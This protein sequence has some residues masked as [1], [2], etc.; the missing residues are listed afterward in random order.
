MNKIEKISVGIPVLNGEKK[1]SNAIES[2]I[3]QDYPNIEIIISN[4][5]S[6]DNTAS[7]CEKYASKDNRIKIFHQRER[8]SAFNNFIFVL[9]ESKGKF[10]KWLAHDDIIQS[11][12]SF[13]IAV[14]KLNEHYD[15]VIP[16]YRV[17]YYNN[18]KLVKSIDNKLDYIENSKTREQFY[19]ASLRESSMFVYSYFNKSKLSENIIYLEKCSKLDVYVEGLFSHAISSSLKGSFIKNL[20][21]IYNVTDTNTSVNFN[22]TQQIRDYLKYYFYVMKF[23]IFENKLSI[24]V[25]IIF[26]TK[27]TLIF[28]N[29]FLRLNITFLKR[30]LIGQ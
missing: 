17:D 12:E 20:K 1:I 22:I 28:I 8:L 14:S 9:N 15:Y 4:N 29:Y 3:K 23:N 18:D 21:F 11:E 24:A 16:N 26:A 6:D 2:I 30:L 5:L 7:I 10:F 25:K 13:S 27:F 19:L